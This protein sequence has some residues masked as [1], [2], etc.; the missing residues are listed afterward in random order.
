MPPIQL[1]YLAKRLHGGK[2][3]SF[4]ADLIWPVGIGEK[5]G[6]QA[7]KPSTGRRGGKEGGRALGVV[8][9]QAG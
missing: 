9:M 6:K 4:K 8:V 2:P 1:H 3:Q 7:S 5:L